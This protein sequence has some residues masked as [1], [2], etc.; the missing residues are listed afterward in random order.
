MKSEK[1]LCQFLSHTSIREPLARFLGS[2][3]PP[4]WVQYRLHVQ[5]DDPKRIHRFVNRLEASRVHVHRAEMV[6]INSFHSFNDGGGHYESTNKGIE[7]I[8][9][10]QQALSSLSNE[11]LLE[12]VHFRRLENEVIRRMRSKENK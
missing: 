2:V 6:D 3:K 12:E 9:N 7:W 11:E 10:K 4:G 1:D 5:T 8:S